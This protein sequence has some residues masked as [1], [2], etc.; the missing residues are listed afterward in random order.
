MENNTDEIDVIELL[1]KCFTFVKKNI[2]LLL[3]VFVLGTALGYYK[4]K[5]RSHPSN[6]YYRTQFIVSSDFLSSNQIYAEGRA[7]SAM[8]LKGEDS[9]ALL[10]K[11]KHLEVTKD[12]VEGQEPE[13]NMVFETNESVSVN[14]FEELIVKKIKANEN[15]KQ[16]FSLAN[17]YYT[18]QLT[19][20][21]GI[22]TENEQTSAEQVL[23]KLELLDK[24]KEL[25]SKMIRLQK[26]VQCMP[27][28]PKNKLY[29][30]PVFSIPLMLGYGVILSLFAALVVFVL[31][32]I[33]QVVSN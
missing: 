25:D 23:E 32:V 16:N 20:L 33:K 7:L 21:K 15:F 30:A 1:R 14:S 10:S 17:R 6:A 4:V 13:V 3:I 29:P 22:E 8:I 11:I 9:D 24:K 2:W 12:V 18:E 26:P 27:I 31:K 28:A 5:Q 19:L